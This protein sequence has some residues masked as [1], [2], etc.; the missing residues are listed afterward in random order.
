MENQQMKAES[1][2]IATICAASL[3]ASATRMG[4]NLV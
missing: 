4:G 3:L 2:K 1:L